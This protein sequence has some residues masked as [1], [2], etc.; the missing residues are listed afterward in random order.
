MDRLGWAL[1]REPGER[2]RSRVAESRRERL[3]TAGDCVF[4]CEVD[5]RVRW[6]GIP[7]SWARANRPGGT[8]APLFSGNRSLLYLS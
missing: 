7:A 6:R 2:V 8:L 3:V 4:P 5:F 1:P